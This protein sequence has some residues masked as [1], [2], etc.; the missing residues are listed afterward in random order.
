VRSTLQPEPFPPATGAIAEVIASAPVGWSPFG[1]PISDILIPQDWT[2]PTEGYGTESF[3]MIVGSKS[4]VSAWNG[5]AWVI[6]DNELWCY[7]RGGGHADYAG[8]EWYRRNVSQNTEWELLTWPSEMHR[9]LVEAGEAG[10]EDRS[11]EILIGKDGRVASGHMYGSYAQ[12]GPD[13]PIFGVNAIPAGPMYTDPW[14]PTAFF[15]DPLTGEETPTPLDINGAGGFSNYGGAVWLSN[16]NLFFGAEGASRIYNSDVSVILSGHAGDMGYAIAYDPGTST[17]VGGLRTGIAVAVLNAEQTAVQSYR[18]VGSTEEL[19]NGGVVSRGNGVF[20][21]ISATGLIHR[22]DTRADTVEEIEFP[23]A[24]VTHRLLNKVHRVSNDAYIVLPSDASQPMH[25][26]KFGQTDGGTQEPVPE[27]APTPDP[28]PSSPLAFGDIDKLIEQGV[29]SDYVDLGGNSPQSWSSGPFGY[30]LKPSYEG[31][32]GNDPDHGLIH[33]PMARLIAQRNTGNEPALRQLC[34]D[35]GNVDL[36]WDDPTKDFPKGTG[37]GTGTFTHFPSA[38]ECAWFLTGKQWYIEE[39]RDAFARNMH[40]NRKSWDEPLHS[41]T[42]RFF[43]WTVMRVLPRLAMAERLGYLEGTRHQDLFRRTV[44][45]LYETRVHNPDERIQNF[46]ILKWD[47]SS[48]GSDT[49]NF[50]TYQS[51]GGQ[52]LA[53]ADIMFRTLFGDNMLTE[54]AEWHSEYFLRLLGQS[55][56]DGPQ[57]C[58]KNAYFFQTQ[59]DS[60]TYKKPGVDYVTQWDQVYYS[61]PGEIYYGANKGKDMRELWEAAPDDQLTNDISGFWTY[62]GYLYGALVLMFKATGKP[63]LKAAAEKIDS[64]LKRIGEVRDYRNTPIL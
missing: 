3:W 50:N 15:W 38:Y 57:G 10:F 8:N 43:G 24:P 33:E 4:V 13:G 35:W 1:P 29:L 18:V 62:P 34:I 56:W 51:F 23:G 6:L 12:K 21:L 16:G 40:N 22:I 27:P 58:L 53:Q 25:I 48:I 59:L 26:L 63:E 44:E 49:G 61:T 17:I 54:M 5:C 28:V 46:R 37:S 30:P 32:G 20:D 42:T 36:P 9:V 41:I 45:M 19:H 64:E 31:A 47:Y 60:D 55:S 52:T 2:H 11:K 39:L 7:A 14:Q